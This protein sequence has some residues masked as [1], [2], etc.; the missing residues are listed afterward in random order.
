[1]ADGFSVDLGALEDAAAGVN[2]TLVDLKAHKVSDLGGVK[3][4]YGHDDLAD[5]V[6]DFC[7]R[8]ELGVENLAKDGQ[9]V[10]TRLS[11][12]VQAYLQV[13]QAAKG[14]FDKILTR[15]TGDDPGVH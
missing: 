2:T 15:T 11:Q 12:S 1:M 3:G 5:T 8:W 6:A 14:M 9:E 10:A 13:D 7:T 4:D